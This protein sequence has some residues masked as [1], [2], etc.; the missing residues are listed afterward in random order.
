MGLEDYERVEV[1]SRAELRAWLAANHQRDEGVWLVA[2]KR[3]DPRHVPY[4]AVVEEALCFGWIDS[5]ARGL[6]AERTMMLLA[7]RR[8]GSKWSR[9]NKARVERLEAA[10]QITPAGRAAIERAHADGS[11]TA[12]DDLENEVVPE[13]LARALDATGDA[14]RHW[15]AFPPGARRAALAWVLDARRPATRERRVREVAAKAAENV[16]AR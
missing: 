16:R 8:K 5:T 10:G 2:W 14:R 15:E 4:D 1:T 9:S 6:D 11:W 12:L 3:A 13:D 7:P